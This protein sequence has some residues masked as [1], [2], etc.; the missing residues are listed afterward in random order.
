MAEKRNMVCTKCGNSFDVYSVKY[1]FDKETKTRYCPECC[2]KYGVE[3]NRDL[4]N[5][6]PK[7]KKKKKKMSKTGK[8]F[9]MLF[10]ILLFVGMLGVVLY[11]MISNVYSDKMQ[12]E[13]QTTYEEKVEQTDTT[14]LDAAI[15]AA[16]AYNRRLVGII[17]VFEDGKVD[18]AVDYKNLLNVNGDGLMAYVEVPIVDINLP[19]YHGDDNAA[20]EKG[21]Q[22][23]LGTSLPV[24]GVDTHSVISAH[25][26]MS[27]K[28]MFTDLESVKVGD[29]FYIKVL[30]KTLAYQ[31]DEINIVEPYDTSLL[32][33]IPGR[34]LVTLVTCTPYAVNTHRLLVR[35]TRIPYEEAKVIEEE[36]AAERK[37]ESNWEQQYIKGILVGAA[38]VGLIVLLYLFLAF[39]GK[40]KKRRQAPF[41]LNKV[42]V[43]DLKILP[44]MNRKK[45]LAIIRYRKENGEYKTL[46]DLDDVPEL[47][48][49][50]IKKIKKYLVIGEE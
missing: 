11:P 40:L 26:G 37:V 7:K 41:D 33:I 49:K 12:S 20:L 15:E 39:L 16:Q 34:D 47:K 35:G 6:P 10:L 25:T 48:E 44:K 28:K 36:K 9:L 3:P 24:G 50:V 31:V 5:Q 18:A 13:I 32:K 38:I 30:H 2:E 17:K 45:A 19:I 27:S 4:K 43:K 1:F 46:D 14:E 23:L 22:H 21:V 29:V 8:F 42:K